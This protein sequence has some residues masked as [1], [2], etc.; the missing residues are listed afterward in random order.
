MGDVASNSAQ[1]TNEIDDSEQQ[2]VQ[3]RP[4]THSDS[5]LFFGIRPSQSSRQAGARAAVDVVDIALASARFEIGRRGSESGHGAFTGAVDRQHAATRVNS[6]GDDLIPTTS[7][8]T[9]AQLTAVTEEHVEA[10]P[11]PKDIAG[12]EVGL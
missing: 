6:S 1:Q 8:T 2:D 12:G 9:A 4:R 10:E 5:S 3:N 11:K 7:A